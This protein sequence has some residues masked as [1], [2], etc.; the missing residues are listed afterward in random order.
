M[1]TEENKALVRRF[2]EEVQSK[3][4]L[5]LIDELFGADFVDHHSG[6]TPP[7]L[8]GAKRF[9]TAIFTA[10]PDLSAMIHEQAA[11]GDKVWTRKTF[12]GT[13][14]GPF[15]G[16]PPTGKAIV[17]VVMD[18]FRIDDGKIV[19]HWGVSDMLGLMQQ[20]GASPLPGQD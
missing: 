10:F 13:H 12:H 4:R 18:V 15:M 7:Y 16:V 14:L 2:I 5:E 8:E 17:V 9:F 11:E 6:S 20:I 3:H 1:S 19:E